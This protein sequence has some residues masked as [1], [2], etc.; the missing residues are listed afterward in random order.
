M[1]QLLDEASFTP[2]TDHLIFTGDL[3][4]KG[5]D[6]AGVVDL[7]REH[8]ASSVRGNHEDRILLLRRSLVAS[9]AMAGPQEGDDQIYTSKEL[10]ERA[11]ARSLSDEQAKWLEACPV[12]LDVGMIS[13]MGR[14]VVV[15]G[16]LVPGVDL[17]NQDPSS[18]MNMRTIDLKTHVPSSSSDGLNWAK[19]RQE[20][21]TALFI[22]NLTNDELDVRQ[23]PI[24][25]IQERESFKV[26]A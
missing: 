22:Q 23:A 16:G 21:S 12:I 5:P 25:L 8:S 7:A 1:V 20:N 26:R 11:L 9:N 18:V 15:H 24:Q 10:G 13:G 19:V 4:N 14:V 2:A 3:I 6:S 17:E